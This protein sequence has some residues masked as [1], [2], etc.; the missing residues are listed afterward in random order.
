[1]NVY[2]TTFDS[3]Y[4]SRAVVLAESFA[5]HCA[6]AEL[7]LCCMDD[8][9][10][11]A[12]SELAL[13]KT[14]PVAHDAFAPAELA[15]LRPLRSAGEYCWTSKPFI[16][17]YAL[18]RRPAAQW[19]VYLDTDTM[20]FGELSAPL[21][22]E[23]GLDALFTPHNLSPE[24]AVYAKHV[25]RF[26][27]GY[28]AFHNSDGGRAALAE[29]RRLCVASCSFEPTDSTFADQRYL[30]DLAA[31][32][33]CEPRSG[34]PG[35]NAAPWNIGGYRVSVEG[36]SALLDGDPLRLYHFQGLRV[37]GDWL[38][39]LYIGNYKLPSVARAAIYAPYIEGLKRAERLVRSR[40]RRLA[41]RHE[42]KTTAR[43]A[44]RVVRRV[45]RGYGNLAV[46]L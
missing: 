21:A 9:A 6:D 36:R 29:W 2:V 8:E 43:E 20:V 10:Y 14:V 16:L 23:P 37:L 34:H 24:F 39:E 31:R 12:M 40:F 17:E 33:R 28:A 44:A 7:Y 18:A 11:A 13:P 30:D 45:L 46:V 27:A 35:L 4:L 22:A 26:N 41:A 3:G 19:T 5:R 1:M 15:S 25:G 38:F 42:R 32:W